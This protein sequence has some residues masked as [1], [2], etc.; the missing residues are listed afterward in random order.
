MNW[1]QEAIDHLN[2]YEAMVMATQNIPREICRLER[3]ATDLRSADPTALR[4]S[5]PGPG[6]DWLIHNLMKRKALNGNLENAKSW[7]CATDHALSVLTPEEKRILL[8]MYIRPEKGAPA[9]LCEEL[10]LEQSS[11]YR[12]R[13]LALY[14][15]TMAL[16]GC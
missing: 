2:R 3:Q 8:R 14:R 11:V 9:R 4:G 12:R 10:G 15:F 1:K 16:Y 13:D 5:Q 7:V 6:D